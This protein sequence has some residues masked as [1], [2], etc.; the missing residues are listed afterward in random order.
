MVIEDLLV[1]LD[2]DPHNS[3]ARLYSDWCFCNLHLL[4]TTAN[5]A[6][7]NGFSNFVETLALVVSH[8]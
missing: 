7:Y 2:K 5:V 1:Y 6:M 4:T 3:P 8:I